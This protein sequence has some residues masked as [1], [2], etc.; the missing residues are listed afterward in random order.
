M[1]GAR[2]FKLFR[3]N[4]DEEQIA[5]T[6][7]IRIYSEIQGLTNL[8]YQGR[9]PCKTHVGG[10]PAVHQVDTYFIVRRYFINKPLLRITG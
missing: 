10:T 3:I 4:V 1:S 9:I 7:F 5:A 8:K 6:L 2:F